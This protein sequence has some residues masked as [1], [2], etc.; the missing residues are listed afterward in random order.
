MSILDLRP[1]FRLHSAL[2]P[3]VVNHGKTA[4]VGALSSKQFFMVSEEF[5]KGDFKFCI[6]IKSSLPGPYFGSRVTRSIILQLIAK[7]IF[8]CKKSQAFSAFTV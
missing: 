2:C 6:Y 1:I 4:N 5:D 3:I 8:Y 7:V